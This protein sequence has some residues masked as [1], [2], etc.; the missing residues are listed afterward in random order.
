MHDQGPMAM[1]TQSA[2][3][4]SPSTTTPTTLSPSSFIPS[5]L[6]I[7]TDAPLATAA[8]II[9][10]V[11]SKGVVWAVSVAMRLAFDTPWSSHVGTSPFS[12]PAWTLLERFPPETLS[13]GSLRQPFSPKSFANCSCMS[14]ET[15]C[16][17]RVGPEPHP[18]ARNPPAFPDAAA[19]TDARSTTVALTPRR[20]SWYA[21]LAATIPPPQTTMFLGCSAMVREVAPPPRTAV[22]RWKLESAGVAENA[23][24]EAE[25][26]STS[27][28]GAAADPRNINGGMRR[29]GCCGLH[30]RG[31]AA[32]P[33]PGW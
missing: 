3:T 23:A 22:G 8:S 28:A 4:V 27:S 29:R 19:A 17:C 2:G 33:K 10:L 6:P 7:L 16:S 13:V 5:T 18:R 31:I 30:V 24:V 14:N 21:R 1:T 11:S 9:A 20:E 26:R 12:I 15:S 25:A 32:L